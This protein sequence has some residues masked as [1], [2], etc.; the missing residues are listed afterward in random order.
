MEGARGRQRLT[1][2]GR[3][4][5]VINTGGV[6]VSAAR[7]Q[8][9]LEALPGVQAAFVGGARDD[10]WGQRVCAAV[11]TA[12]GH[13]P[14]DQAAA[15]EAIRA[16]LGPA[17]VPKQ[18]LVLESLPLLPNGKTDRQSLLTRFTT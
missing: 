14:F 16:Q 5:D 17:A 7:V 3:V 10:E 18:W 13:A 8:Q 9:V 1:V 6:K 4:D 11:T 2:S 15:R 12:R